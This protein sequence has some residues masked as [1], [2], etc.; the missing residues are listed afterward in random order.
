MTLCQIISLVRLFEPCEGQSP[1][2][3]LPWKSPRP[4]QPMIN[5]LLHLESVPVSWTRRGICL[6]LCLSVQMTRCHFRLAGG[7]LSVMI[8]WFLSPL[9]WLDDFEV[10]HSLLFHSRCRCLGRMGGDN[11]CSQQRKEKNPTGCFFHSFICDRT[12]AH[13]LT[14]SEPQMIQLLQLKLRKNRT[15]H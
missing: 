12:G 7:P 10:S 9:S 6:H 3:L 5:H 1:L 11:S 2:L 13:Y 8:Y 15:N 14:S 4:S